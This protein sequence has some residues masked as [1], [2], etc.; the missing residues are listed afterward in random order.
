MI[1][2]GSPGI[3]RRVMK[4]II[5]MPNNTGMACNTR[6]RT[7]FAILSCS[8]QRRRY[9]CTPLFIQPP[10][11]VAHAFPE[12][13]ALGGGPMALQVVPPGHQDEVIANDAHR[14]VPLQDLQAP[15]N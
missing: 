6:H 7:Y 12:V 3:M 2:T 14:D 11:F 9:L 15:G 13:D 5:V 10:D 8:S 1:L 4:M